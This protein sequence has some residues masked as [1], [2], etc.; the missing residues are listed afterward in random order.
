MI[1]TK[2]KLKN[3]IQ[4]TLDSLGIPFAFKIPNISSVV[5]RV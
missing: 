5:E 4:K 2:S 3:I 1:S